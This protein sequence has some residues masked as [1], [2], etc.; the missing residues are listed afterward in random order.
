MSQLVNSGFAILVY[1]L[2]GMVVLAALA[3]WI[4]PERLSIPHGSVGLG[5]TLIGAAAALL[6]GLFL[7]RISMVVPWVLERHYGEPVI[8]GVIRQFPD[9]PLLKKAVQ[10]KYAPADTSLLNVYLLAQA[11]LEDASPRSADEGRRLR[12]IA[13][14]CRNLIIAAPATLLLVWLGLRQLARHR[15]SEKDSLYPTRFAR[16]WLQLAALAGSAVFSEYIL[17]K[18]YLAYNAASVRWTLRALLIML[19]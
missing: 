1:L 15:S 13:L 8:H 14:L 6:V 17:L 12:S 3:F 18:S 7:L 9:L 11:A 5:E 16:E 10:Q 4:L 19:S 2:P